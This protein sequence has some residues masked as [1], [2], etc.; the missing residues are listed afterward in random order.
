MKLGLALILWLI[1]VAVAMGNSYV[2]NIYIGARLGEYGGHVYKTVVLVVVIFVLAWLYAR[3]TQ[4]AEW[5]SAA[6]GVGLLWLGLTIAFEFIFG[7]YVIGHSWDKLLADYR[8]WQGRL[9][10]LVLISELVSPMIMGW[11]LNR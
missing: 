9:W 10:A 6:L 2:G 1:A 8:I 4:G 11:R 3:R 7:H 5:F